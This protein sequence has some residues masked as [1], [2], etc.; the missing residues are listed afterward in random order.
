MYENKKTCRLGVMQGRLLPKH[1][2]RYQAHPV[3]YWRD[4]FPIA[5]ELGL[6]LIEFIY[7]YNDVELNPLS[8]IQGIKELNKTIEKTE[9]LVKTICAD[10]FMEAPLHMGDETEKSKK[11][12]INL[13]NNAFE[14]GVEII[15]IPCVDHS[16]LSN[17][18]E[19]SLFVENLKPCLEVAHNKNI[20]LSLETD[21]GPKE[22]KDLLNKISHPNISVNYDS[23]NSASLGYKV[24]EEFEA[25]GKYVTDIHIKDRPLGEGSV[26]LGQGNVDFNLFIDSIPKNYIGPIIMQAFRDDEGLEVFKSQL[27]WIKPKLINFIN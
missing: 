9:V 15:V 24:N 1:N 22:F 19:K 20:S 6:D 3:G 18:E 23:G 12:L 14:I 11:T 2:G 13:I 4:E 27:N 7:D 5:K 10:Y 21:L 8:S 25:Y 17:E 16:T 26:I